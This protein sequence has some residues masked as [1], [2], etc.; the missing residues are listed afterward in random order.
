MSVGSTYYTQD[1]TE[2]TDKEESGVS[3]NS[4][5]ASEKEKCVR[6]QPSAVY[7][8]VRISMYLQVHLFNVWWGRAVISLTV[9][10]NLVLEMVHSCCKVLNA[11]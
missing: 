8:I 6:T 10:C 9:P 5:L 2:V 4:C 1:S 7:E 3:R 11:E